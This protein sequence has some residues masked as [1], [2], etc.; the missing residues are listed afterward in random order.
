MA[1]DS[2]S[3]NLIN[4]TRMAKAEIVMTAKTVSVRIGVFLR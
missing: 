2:E 3:M 1:T 4:G